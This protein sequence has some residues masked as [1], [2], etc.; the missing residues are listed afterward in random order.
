MP[1]IA[2]AVIQDHEGRF[3]METRADPSDRW[4]GISCI[5]GGHIEANESPL[6]A[7]AREA[8]EELGITP[9]QTR[10]LGSYEF[11]G[12][13]YHYF[14]VIKHTGRPYAKEGQR[15]FY[16][17]I[18]DALDELLPVEAQFI[19]SKFPHSA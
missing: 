13:T 14:H 18:A 15:I 4:F 19:K 9:V 5:P 2:L 7:L 12:D 6:Q 3:L 10:S 16:S 1:Q 8:E 11:D 17:T